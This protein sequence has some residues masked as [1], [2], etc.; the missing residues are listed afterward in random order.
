MEGWGFEI[1]DTN[2]PF[3]TN[4]TI[5]E[6]FAI[7]EFPETIVTTEIHEDQNDNK[8]FFVLDPKI[9]QTEFQMEEEFGSISNN[10]NLLSF[11]QNLNLEQRQ[12]LQ[13][14][15][16]QQQQQLELE[17][18]LEKEKQKEDDK[19]NKIF[20]KIKIK[21]KIKKK[22]KKREMKK[23]KIHQNQKITPK[24]S[25][26]FNE[27]K[28]VVLKSQFDQIRDPNKKPNL[29]MGLGKSFPIKQ[30]L[31]KIHDFDDS[32][33]IGWTKV[34]PSNLIKFTPE[35]FRVYCW[36]FDQN[37]KIA[38]NSIKKFFKNKTMSKYNFKF[39][40]VIE[41]EKSFLVFRKH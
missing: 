10:N 26:N 33:I 38:S 13:Q 37:K 5:E 16:Q 17:L 3:N 39:E 6:E 8:Q 27:Q 24:S 1:V 30:R 22:K 12:E 21:K 7:N 20:K 23:E 15:Q 32:L 9:I 40:T 41:N 25:I 31:N 29:K 14:Q 18:E 28:W 36:L 2:Y 34:R 11:H 35:F 19:E 4:Q